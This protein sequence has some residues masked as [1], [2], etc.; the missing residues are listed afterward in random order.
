MTWTRHGHHI[1]GTIMAEPRPASVARCGSIGL[2]DG[3]S[4]DAA[5]VMNTIHAKSQLPN[6]DVLIVC[7]RAAGHLELQ[8]LGEGEA[9]SLV[10]EAPTLHLFAV[11]PI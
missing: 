10:Q 8:T 4:K 7:L 6:D 5:R 2:C 11:R 9:A 3:C 1:P